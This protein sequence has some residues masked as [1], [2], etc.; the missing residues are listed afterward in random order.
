MVQI[1]E[2]IGILTIVKKGGYTMQECHCAQHCCHKKVKTEDMTDT[3]ESGY[4]FSFVRITCVHCGQ[5]IGDEV[6]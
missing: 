3:T 4:E 1:I 2:K 5:W 6:Q